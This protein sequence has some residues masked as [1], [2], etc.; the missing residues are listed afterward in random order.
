LLLLSIITLFTGPLLYLWLSKGG[1]LARTIDRLVVVMLLLLVVML[2][3]PEIIQPLGLVTAV[4]LVIVGYGLPGMLELVVRRAAATMH[5]ASLLLALIGL[6]LHALLD[7][8]G[9]ASSELGS[10]FG[11][12]TAIV[13]HRFGVGLMLWLIMQPA[14]GQRS[15]WG[16]L[17]AMAGATIIGFE[18]SERLLPLTGAEAILWIEAVIIGTIIHSLIHRGHVHH[19]H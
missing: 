14:F 16:M 5:L 15:A 3:L 18:F 17:V 11:L 9:L 13:L 1:Q 10:G 4:A 8:A 12:A 6:L 2:L 19:A 7:G